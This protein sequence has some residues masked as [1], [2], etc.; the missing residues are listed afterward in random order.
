MIRWMT[1]WLIETAIAN[2][3]CVCLKVPSL[4]DEKKFRSSDLQPA[5]TAGLL[6][7][8]NPAAWR[9]LDRQQ[10]AGISR[11]RDR[12]V[13]N[14]RS[15]CAV[16]W[17][18]VSLAWPMQR[19]IR[20]EAFRYVRS[21]CY[22]NPTQGPWARKKFLCIPPTFY[23]TSHTPAAGSQRQIKIYTITL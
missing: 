17:H 1:E 19:K 14:S 15:L 3:S 22:P 11:S 2:A 12:R 20:F 16:T 7:L 21:L 6:T 10:A 18:S 4:W 5:L 23:S 13:A 8:R 9:P